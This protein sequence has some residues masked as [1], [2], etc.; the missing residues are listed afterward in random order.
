MTSSLNVPTSPVVFAV[1]C[2]Q[3]HQ[4]NT[5]YPIVKSLILQPLYFG[6]STIILHIF[7]FHNV[8]LSFT[9]SLITTLDS[10][11][12]LHLSLCHYFTTIHKWPFLYHHLGHVQYD[13]AQTFTYP[14]LKAIKHPHIVTTTVGISHS[15]I[16]S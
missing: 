5:D 8:M 10:C 16:S 7:L 4:S 2:Q 11:P 3:I 13:V 1:I 9:P 12:F 14:K 15:R 6:Q